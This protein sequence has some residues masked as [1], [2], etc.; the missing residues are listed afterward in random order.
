MF[1]FQLLKNL[2]C[3]Y[4]IFSVCPSAGLCVYAPFPVYDLLFS[5]G[6]FTMF[7]YLKFSFL[8]PFLAQELVNPVEIWERKHVERNTTIKYNR[9]MYHQSHDQHKFIF[10]THPQKFENLRKTSARCDPGIEFET[11]CLSALCNL[12]VYLL[13]RSVTALRVARVTAAAPCVGGAEYAPGTAG[14]TS[15]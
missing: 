13:V 15:L 8:F 5:A 12:C 4:F 3:F 6:T 9:S 7:P 11:R 14:T 2:Y 10:G 1:F